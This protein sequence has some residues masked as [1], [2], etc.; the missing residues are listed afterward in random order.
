MPIRCFALSALMLVLLATPGFAEE[1]AEP[2]DAPTEVQWQEFHF[3][4]R[5]FVASFPGITKKPKPVS[6]PVSGQNPLLQHTYQAKAPEDSVYDC[7]RHPWV[8]LPSGISVFERNPTS[9]VRR[10][11]ST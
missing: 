10:T 3:P 4:E 2:Q 6:T 7:R 5:G 9:P 11:N 8:Q 1:V